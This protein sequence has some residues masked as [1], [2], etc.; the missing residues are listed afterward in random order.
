MHMANTPLGGLKGVF[1]FTHYCHTNFLM[2][3]KM[4]FARFCVF[5]MFCLVL[6]IIFIM[7]IQH[8][9]NM[10]KEQANRN[11]LEKI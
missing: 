4:K 6:C 8:F 5:Q 3:A 2:N 1:S 7:R 10:V 11:N 9:R